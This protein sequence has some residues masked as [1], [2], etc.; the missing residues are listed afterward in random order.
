MP[1]SAA[2]PET[3]LLTNDMM[4]AMDLIGVFV[5]GIVGGALAR[6]LQFDAVGFAFIGIVSGLGGGIIRDLILAQ[7]VPAAFSTPWYLAASL[8]GVLIAFLISVDARIWRHSTTVLDAVAL[9]VWAAIGCAKS[10]GAGLSPL[11]SILLGLTTAVGGGVI[12]DV[13]VGRIP[14]I[15]TGGP[16][17]A[18]AALLTAVLTWGVDALNLPSWIVVLAALAGTAVA[19]LA[20]WRRWS[21]PTAPDLAVTLSPVQMRAFVR[22]VRREERQRVAA[23]TGQIP[24]LDP[25][26]LVHDSFFNVEGTPEEPDSR[27]AAPPFQIHFPSLRREHDHDG[28]MHVDDDDDDEAPFE[29]GPQHHRGR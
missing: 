9:G 25:Q 26:D 4:R 27:A 29:S 8:A 2:T 21:L 10:L 14:G 22:R 5:M 13:M 11:P 24:V 19:I 23:E 12:R 20:Q 1:S 15:F 17:Y 16:L 18:T 28:A 6:R 7:G 3:F